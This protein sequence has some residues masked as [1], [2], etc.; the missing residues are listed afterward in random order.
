MKDIKVF[1]ATHKK[2]QMPLDSIYLPIQVGAHKKESLGYVRDD[3]GYNIS[4]KNPFFCELT[5][6]YWAVNNFDA[7]YIGLVHYRRHFSETKAHEKESS[8]RLKHALSGE[9][10]NELLKET[11]IILPKKRNYYIENLYDH[12]KHTMYIE[13]LDEAGKI[14]EYYYPEFYPEFKRLKKRTS[15][16]MFNMIIAKKSILEDYCNWLFDI[17]FKLEE[18]IDM[19]VY[20]DFHARFY[21]RVSELLLDVYINTKG[22]S[23]KEVPVLDVEKVDW[24]KKG[25]AFL[26]AKFTGRK[27]AKSF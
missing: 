4:S 20:D 23:Y 15:A 5:G 18:R 13:P 9:R 22:L 27:Y 3:L 25:F 26:S 10:I 14:I 8:K 12:Y 16:H 21:G 2:Y 1:V 7:D 17:L 24:F 19:S 6:L 11:D